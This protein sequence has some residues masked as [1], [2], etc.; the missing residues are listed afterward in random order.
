MKTINIGWLLFLI[1]AGIGGCKTIRF[2]YPN[3]GCSVTKY[4]VTNDYRIF[5]NPM[6][7]RRQDKTSDEGWSMLA[8]LPIVP[9]VSFHNYDM[10]G[11]N[12]DVGEYDFRPVDEV[13]DACITHI[14]LSGIARA[15]RSANQ[16]SK[17]LNVRE[18]VLNIKLHKIGIAGK[19]TCYCL[20][21]IP[22]SYIHFFGAPM[23]YADSF[24]DLEFELR[25]LSDRVVFQKR[26]AERQ[27]YTVSM[28]K[29]WN[30]LKFVGFN[31]NRIM[32]RFCAEVQDVLE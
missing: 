13:L 8:E 21:W 10:Q 26:Y 22:G 9:Y 1:I 19:R 4:D 6:D 24:L 25:D 16:S 14:N 18:F 29:N 2:E 32:N 31:L 12:A 7:D 27:D 20:G 28:Y 5:V 23:T 3:A 17:R 30:N 15:R 11:F